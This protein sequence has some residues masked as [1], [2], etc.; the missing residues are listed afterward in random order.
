MR[1]TLYILGIIWLLIVCF[2]PIEPGKTVMVM[3]IR[4]E[5]LQ[6]LIP[7]VALLLACIY[8]V[9]QSWRI[10][11]L[12]NTKLW[13]YA[14][15]VV[16]FYI[17]LAWFINSVFHLGVPTFGS[18][19]TEGVLMLLFALVLDTLKGKTI[20]ARAWFLAVTAV[21]ASIGFWEILYQVCS[22]TSYYHTWFP[23][24][25]LVYN[26]IICWRPHLLMVIPFICLLVFYGKMYGYNF[27][28]WALVPAFVFVAF[29]IIWYFVGDYWIIW[30]YDHNKFPPEWTYNL[31]IQWHWYL[32][33]RGSKT[34]LALT[35]ILLVSGIVKATPK[36]R[37]V[38]L[39]ACCVIVIICLFYFILRP[40]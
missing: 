10:W 26:E 15:L 25:A 19:N 14:S 11:K 22:W 31:P 12:L 2:V 36:P 23:W 8:E 37:Y 29:W 24:Y 1:K 28:K 33:A 35:Q 7:L 13:T 40:T 6:F 39:V 9:S 16:L 27:S 5:G 34:I 20:E 30:Y 4:P 3:S 18:C 21:F 17:A 38:S 32:G